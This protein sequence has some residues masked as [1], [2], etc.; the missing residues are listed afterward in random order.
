[1]RAK[2]LLHAVSNHDNSYPFMEPVDVT[3]Y[4]VSRSLNAISKHVWKSEFTCPEHLMQPMPY[5]CL[6]GPHY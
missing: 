2:E 1:M 4:P 5:R 3:A 6:R